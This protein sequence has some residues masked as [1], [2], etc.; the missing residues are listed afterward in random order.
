[1]SAVLDATRAERAAK[2]KEL[3]KFLASVEEREVKSMTD[4][5]DE[6][7]EA[8][9]TSIKKI[10]KRIG[11]LVDA[12][13]R[14][15]KAA[16]AAAELEK[17]VID[18]AYVR[19]EPMT[20]GE[21]Q[22]HRSGSE[23]YVSY[24][25][26]LAASSVN[27]FR[28]HDA[29][30]ARERL[31]RHAKEVDVEY[32]AM[33]TDEKR[34]FNQFLDREAGSYESRVNPNTTAGTGGEFVPPLWL[35]AQYV[36]FLRPARVAANRVRN[37]PLPPGIDV[38]NL[39]KITTGSLTAVQA[40][41]AA[42]VASQDIVTATVS[43]N[44]NTIAGQEDISMQLLDQSPIAMDGVVFDDLSRDY[45]QRLDL[46]VL[47]GTGSNG[48]H[49]GV[50]T[51]TAASAGI[52]TDITKIN[53][54]TCAS[55]VFADA[56]TTGTQFRSIGSARTSIEILRLMSP[57]A[58]WV[59]PRKANH[60]EV[61][62]VDTTGRPLYVPYSP[63][64]AFGLDNP[65]VPEGVAG[66]LSGLPVIKDGNIPT[67]C[68]TGA[69][70]GGTGDMIGVVKEDDFYLWEGTMRMRALPEILSGTLQIRF[71]VYAYSAFMPHRFPPSTSLITGTTGLATPT[72]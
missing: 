23:T 24:F 60:W 57:T 32:R 46:Q 64:N 17:P 70:T 19:S 48:Q 2:Q 18:G 68:V 41:N 53:A 50:F 5:D 43:A 11:K 31:A 38:I 10:D 22:A 62:A 15:A 45:D 25:R 52:N 1:M 61:T 55:T 42:P 59:H 33:S 40:A 63:Y 9:A 7:F 30:L 26:D 51:Q 28:D 34:T 36:P 58:I 3:D 21:E 44:V 39:P 37:L 27:G 49:K 29:S 4:E 47:V 67:T 14:E 69:T 20:Y 65:N 54:A 71:Q 8:L 16:L 72:F 13:E 56:S 12:E 66:T 35:V 6:T